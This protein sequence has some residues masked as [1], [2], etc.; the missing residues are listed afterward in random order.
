MSLCPVPMLELRGPRRT[1]GIAAVEFLIT[2]P[3]ILLLLFG[4][5]ELWRTF[6][7]Y[8]TL[9]HLVRDSA[10]FVSSHSL[11]GTTGVVALTGTVINQA[12]HLAVYGNIWGTGNPK[13]PN[14]QTGQVQVTDVDSEIIRVAA[15]YPYQPLFFRLPKLGFQGGGSIPTTFNMYI[16]VT[17][18][19]IN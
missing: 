5:A 1:R 14:L 15:T 7:H 4:G 11:D 9:S 10:R 3:F 13:L 17:M 16:A 2:A 18:R 19:A 6:V 8:A 12:R